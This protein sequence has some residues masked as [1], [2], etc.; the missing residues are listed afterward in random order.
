MYSVL[1]ERDYII[2]E[3]DHTIKERDHTIKER[4][5]IIK[6]RD[7]KI[8]TLSKDNAAKDKI[9]AELERRLKQVGLN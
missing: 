3:R 2:K 9:I 8:V 7:Q 1:A 4:D 5:H 6:E